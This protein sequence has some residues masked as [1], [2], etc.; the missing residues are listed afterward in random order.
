MGTQGQV[1]GV[2][3]GLT[4]YAWKLHRK[5]NSKVIKMKSMDSNVT[6][7]NAKRLTKDRG[8]LMNWRRIV[9]NS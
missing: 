6:K 1:N 2:E 8:L 9:L 3:G 4:Q 7:L 5:A